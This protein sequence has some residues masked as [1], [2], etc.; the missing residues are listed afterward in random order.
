MTAF[1][2]VKNLIKERV[3]DMT[4]KVWNEKQINDLIEICIAGYDI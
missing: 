1:T 4:V 3:E 2:G